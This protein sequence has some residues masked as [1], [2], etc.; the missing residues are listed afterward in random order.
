MN[1]AERRRTERARRKSKPERTPIVA[2]KTP[3]GLVVVKSLL[4][5]PPQK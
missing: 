1:R 3:S 5:V 4:V 2:G